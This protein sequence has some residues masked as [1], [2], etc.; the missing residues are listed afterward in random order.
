M[1]SEITLPLLDKDEKEKRFGETISSFEACWN[2]FKLSSMCFLGTMFIPINV[3]VNT[4]V[5]GHQK[6]AN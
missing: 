3:V 5:M 2:I 4:A 1:K 6:D